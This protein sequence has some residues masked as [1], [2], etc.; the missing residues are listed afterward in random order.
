[1]FCAMING[2]IAVWRSRLA[3]GRVAAGHQQI[4]GDRRNDASRR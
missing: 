1:M 4:H 2:L 3:G